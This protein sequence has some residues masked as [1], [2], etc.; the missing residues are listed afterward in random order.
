MFFLYW[1]GESIRYRHSGLF[2][3]APGLAYRERTGFNARICVPDRV[4]RI[5][6]DRSVL[7]GA[8]EQ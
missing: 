3:R 7:C 1:S 8:R 5:V 4:G 6:E 2:E